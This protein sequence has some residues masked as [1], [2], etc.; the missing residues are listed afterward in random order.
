[1]SLE[2]AKMMM[3]YLLCDISPSLADEGEIEDRLA[4]FFGRRRRC[5]L[6]CT[7]Y[8]RPIF[9]KLFTMRTYALADAKYNLPLEVLY[10]HVV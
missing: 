6:V 7:A 9:I 3:Q 5:Y 4:T 1:M 8:V 2:V 10:L